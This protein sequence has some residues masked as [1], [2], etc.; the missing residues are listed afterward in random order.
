[1]LYFHFKQKATRFENLQR[2][3]QD[4]LEINPSAKSG[5]YKIRV[6]HGTLEVYCEMS[7]ASRGYT[8]V[9]IE[10]VSVLTKEDLSNLFTD[11]SHVLLR[12]NKKD[13]SQPY[14]VIRQRSV[15]TVK[16]ISVQL[17]EYK[18]YASPVNVH[19][20]PYLYLGIQ[21]ASIVK[22]DK[23]LGFESNGKNITYN[24]CG[25]PTQSL[26]AFFPNAKELPTANGHSHNLVYERLGVAVDWRNSALRAP[27]GRR[28]PLDFF[29]F[30]EMYFGG[31]GCYTESQRWVDALGTAI[32][33]R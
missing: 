7:L 30:T 31:C 22:K 20:G 29:L 2:S 13:G 6:S 18:G 1:M 33:V 24:V 21:P 4:I 15:S 10:G 28:I 14:T 5:I 19:M 23:V 32:G 26:L 9:S 25:V 27:S 16:E 12:I 8:F 17:S 11:K 3:C